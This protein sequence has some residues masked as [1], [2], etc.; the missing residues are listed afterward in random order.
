MK[1]ISLNILNLKSLVLMLLLVFLFIVPVPA[2]YEIFWY[3]IDGGGGMSSGGP[4]SMTATIGQADASVSSGGP[5]EILSGFLPG[6]PICIVNFEH[7][8][9]LANWW[10]VSSCG[11]DNDWCDG[12][13]MVPNGVVDAN[14]LEMFVDY[15]LYLCPVDWP[16]K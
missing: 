14:D 1:K 4:Y 16:L 15:W 9:I 12:A 7:Y 6:G 2:E 11:E 13:D 10:L 5:Y 8:A 3:T